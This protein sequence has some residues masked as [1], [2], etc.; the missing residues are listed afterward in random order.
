MEDDEGE[1]PLYALAQGFPAQDGAGWPLRG[2]DRFAAVRTVYPGG[3]T[4]IRL[5][6]NPFLELEYLFTTGQPPGYANIPTLD[7]HIAWLRQR[8]LD[9]GVAVVEIPPV[10]QGYDHMACL[11]HDVDFAAIRHYLFTP[12][13]LGFIRRATLNTWRE[14]WRGRRPW[15]DVWRNLAAVLSL[16]LVALGMASDFWQ[17][18]SRYMAI[19]RGLH[20]TFFFIPFK[21]QAGEDVDLPHPER[22]ATRYDVDDVVPWLNQLSAQGFEVGVHG[23]DGWRDADA[24]AR[25]LARV[26]THAPTA[27]GN[28]THW[29]CADTHSP[30]RLEQA[31]F[32]YDATS[33]YN[34]TIGFKVGI[35]QAFKPLGAQQLLELPM[36]IQDVAM[37][38]PVYLNWTMAQAEQHCEAIFA[39]ARCHGGV[40]TLLWHD[41]SLAPERLWDDIYLKL[42][43]KLQNDRVRFGSAQAI[44]AWFR[45]RRAIRFSGHVDEITVFCAPFPSEL[46]MPP[47][48]VWQLDASRRAQ[49]VEYALPLGT[50]QVRPV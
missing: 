44:A 28:R 43:E 31:G 38:Y 46:P 10:P 49:Y 37:F 24:G 23:L 20:S 7:R 30:L 18:F 50:S 2:R 19:E 17:Q 36:H 27:C 9:A 35:L 1:I 41:R 33:G 13:L 42:L 14:A 48:R 12:T 22:R 21:H 29:L 6:F 45:A 11:T 16:P 26:R 39:H 34:D 15:R 40:I 8:I 25:E 4:E 32:E 5:A 47:V 3:A